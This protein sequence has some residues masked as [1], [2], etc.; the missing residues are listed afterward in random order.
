MGLNVSQSRF[1]VLASRNSKQALIAEQQRLLEAE[2]KKLESQIKNT[3]NQ[4]KQSENLNKQPEN[5]EKLT[6]SLEMLSTANQ[7]EQTMKKVKILDQKLEFKKNYLEEHSM[8]TK[9]PAI[10]TEMEEAQK[11]V[12][13]NLESDQPGTFKYFG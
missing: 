13:S 7:Y 2:K 1:L 9:H 12:K 6:D 3:D 10:T 5:S 8:K 4:N 11:I